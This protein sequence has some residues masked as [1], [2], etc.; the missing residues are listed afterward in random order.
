MNRWSLPVATLAAFGLLSLNALA[1]SQDNKSYHRGPGQA[2]RN[3]ARRD[4]PAPAT[5]AARKHPP[6]R[7]PSSR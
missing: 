2:N 4:K 6:R 5:D 3:R 7:P 1:Q